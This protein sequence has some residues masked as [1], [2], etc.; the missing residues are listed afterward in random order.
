MDIEF[1]C[2]TQSAHESIEDAL[3]ASF[4]DKFTCGTIGCQDIEK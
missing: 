1:I 2:S 4:G 3:K